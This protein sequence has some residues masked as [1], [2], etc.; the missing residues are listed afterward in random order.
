MRRINEK[1]ASLF[2]RLAVAKSGVAAIELG[3]LFPMIALLIIPLTDLGMGAYT[4]M[5]VNDAAQAGA[6]YAARTAMY[7]FSSANIS[8]AVTNATTL[9]GLSATPAPTLQCGCANGSS[10]TFYAG[11]PPCT[12]T[13]SVGGPGTYVTVSTQAKYTPFFGYGLL[14]LDGTGA[15]TLTAQSIVRIN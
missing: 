14:P 1:V 13:C 9:S 3:L 4:Q 15:M 12:Q 10:V 5:Q 8:N 11:S 7:G 6:D 2:S